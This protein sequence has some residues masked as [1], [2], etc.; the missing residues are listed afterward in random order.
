MRTAWEFGRLFMSGCVCLI[1]KSGEVLALSAN[2]YDLG[3]GVRPVL[4]L[5]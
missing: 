5:T 1:D 4:Q 3:L 2:L